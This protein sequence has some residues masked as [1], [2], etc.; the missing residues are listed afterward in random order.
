M[1]FMFE[2]CYK[3]PANPLKEATL[4]DRV[5]AL[6]GH[7]DFREDQTDLTGIILTFEFASLDS[8]VRAANDL[9]ESGEHVEGPAEYGP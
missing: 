4:S 2:V 9:R 5:Q 8:A 6:G 3:P 1:S 7:L